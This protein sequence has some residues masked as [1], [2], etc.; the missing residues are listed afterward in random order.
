LLGPNA[1]AFATGRR[2]ELDLEV[3]RGLLPEPAAGFT[4]KLDRVER[5]IIGAGGVRAPGDAGNTSTPLGSGDW[6][7]YRSRFWTVVVRPDTAS[8]LMPRPEGGLA[9]VAAEQGIVSWSYV[10]YSGPVEYKALT[11]A[12]P[13]LGRLLF[14]GLWSWLRALSL[15]LLHLLHSLIALT[16]NAGVAIVALAVSVKIAL[17]PLAAV[18]HRLQDQVNATQSRL[19][20]GIEAINAAYKGE[21]RARR[22]LAL[23]REQGVHP[24]YT[25]KSLVGFLIQFP[26]FIAVFDM[27]A[28]NFDLYRVP[29]LWIRDLSRPDDLLRLPFCLPFFG[30]YLNLLPFLMSGI[31]AAALLRFHSAVL[32]PSLVRRQRRNLLGMTLLFFV[33]FYTFPA[34]MVLYWTSTNA[35]QLVSQELVRWWRSR[36]PSTE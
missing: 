34:G 17:V 24:M 13:D 10:F 8:A 36:R 27:L 4:A 29:F 3:G 31:S 18:A 1:A 28:E 16:G 20:P 26:V 15:V 6:V 22:T 9:L 33:L 32:T 21:E 11:R 2:L 5:V 19:Q 25:V 14:A 23:Y 35:V 30:C 12:D 7:G